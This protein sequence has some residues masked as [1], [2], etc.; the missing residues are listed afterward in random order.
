MVPGQEG[1]LP[2]PV[3]GRRQAGI[4]DMRH[5]PYCVAASAAL[6]GYVACASWLF[7][8]AHLPP[9]GPAVP[10]CAQRLGLQL[11]VPACRLRTLVRQ[12]ACSTVAQGHV[13]V[14]ARRFTNTGGGDLPHKS[15]WRARTCDRVDAYHCLLSAR[16][17]GASR[18]AFL[19]RQ[20]PQMHAPHQ[21]S[22][23]GGAQAHNR[24]RGLT[25][26]RT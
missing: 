3:P 25:H 1:L 12:A 4:R 16:R 17:C 22:V 14:P 8:D 13:A 10:L 23:T 20:Q 6:R 2:A 11:C 21:R 7:I 18:C 5:W 19:D 9:S 15:S 26:A 24:A